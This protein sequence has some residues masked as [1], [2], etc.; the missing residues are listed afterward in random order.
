MISVALPRRKSN[1][2]NLSYKSNEQKTNWR[3]TACVTADAS[4]K[5]ATGD[6]CISGDGSSQTITMEMREA[7][8]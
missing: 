1:G 2:T 7:V 3:I 4:I 8:S 5:D 6:L